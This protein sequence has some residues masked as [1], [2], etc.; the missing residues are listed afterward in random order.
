MAL[1]LPSQTE[2]RVLS[3]GGVGDHHAET[4]GLVPARAPQASTDTEPWLSCG[5]SSLLRDHCIGCVLPNHFRSFG[6]N[7]QV[8]TT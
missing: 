7:D 1:Q 2:T 4:V 5:T 8:K 6:G 3:P